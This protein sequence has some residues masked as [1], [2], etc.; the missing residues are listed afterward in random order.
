MSNL[1]LKNNLSPIGVSVYNRPKH[2]KKLFQSLLLNKFVKNTEIYIFCDYQKTDE[3]IENVNTVRKYIRSLEGFKKKSIIFRDKNFGL[4]KN[5]IEG[6]NY[7]FERHEKLIWLEDDKEL[8]PYFLKYMNEGLEFYKDEKKIMSISGYAFPTKRIE[9]SNSAVITR[10]MICWAWGTWKNRWQYFSN[11]IS[12]MKKFTR[13]M[14]YEFNFDNTNLFWKQLVANKSGRNET[15]AIFWYASIFINKG[16]CVCPIE[17]L[18]ID[19]GS[20]GSGEHIEKTEIFTNHLS[21]RKNFIFPEKI[22]E[23]KKYYEY[24]KMYFKSIKPT[25]MHRIFFR[26]KY[27][28]KRLL[29]I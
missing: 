13:N 21:S 24:L 2:T 15:W 12:I 1:N 25:L 16:L 7:I 22:E 5:I 9:S 14:K 8:S 19:T 11:D 6:V 20:D 10:L 4:A 23:N 29:N 26:L 18:A 28:I 17:T 3:D 27:E